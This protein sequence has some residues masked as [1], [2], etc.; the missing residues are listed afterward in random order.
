M[1]THT[2]IVITKLFGALHELMTS[3][4]I[5]ILQYKLNNFDTLLTSPIMSTL[6]LQH[7]VFNGQ[8]LTTKLVVT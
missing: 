3:I 4:Y 2:Y 7:I 1:R 6:L 5:N 8:S